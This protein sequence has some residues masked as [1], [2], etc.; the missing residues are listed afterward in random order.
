MRCVSY[1]QVWK[2]TF[3]LEIVC[4]AMAILEDEFVFKPAYK[5]GEFI[6]R[7]NMVGKK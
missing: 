6:G 5:L 4:K 7:P 1:L 2:A 3:E